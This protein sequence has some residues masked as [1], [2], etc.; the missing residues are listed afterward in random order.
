[1]QPRQ[2]SYKPLQLQQILLP[3]DF[4]AWAEQMKASYFG[5]K[6]SV[7]CVK[8]ERPIGWQ[9]RDGWV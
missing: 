6:S 4:T 9:D 5:G 7:F 2:P 8:E 1:M 3:N